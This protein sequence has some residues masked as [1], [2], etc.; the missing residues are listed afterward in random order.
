MKRDRQ[1]H[2]PEVVRD[3]SVAVYMM[4]LE[5]NCRGDVQRMIDK[6]G[7]KGAKLRN[8]AREYDALTRCYLK[9]LEV[10]P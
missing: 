4:R 10:K 7:D 8:R 1:E 6:D 5:Q 9:V 2:D 3:V